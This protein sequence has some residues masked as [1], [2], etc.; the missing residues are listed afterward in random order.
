M[1]PIW[2]YRASLLDELA[3]PSQQM[4][5]RQSQDDRYENAKIFEHLMSAREMTTLL[6]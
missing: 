1:H 6:S 4:S 5:Q 3:Q 2:L